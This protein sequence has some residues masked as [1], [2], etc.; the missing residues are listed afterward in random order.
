VEQ[1]PLEGASFV[2]VLRDGDAAPTRTTQHFEMLGSRAIYHDGWKA[3]TFKPLGPMYDDGLD[4]DAPFDEDRWELYHVAEDH[5]E[6]HDLAD[7][8]PDRLAAM[9]ERWWAEARAHQVLPLDNRPLAALLAPRPSSASRDRDRYS[10]FAGAAPVPETVAVNVRNRSHAMS[11][12]VHVPPGVVAYGVLL[13][14]GSTLGGWSLYLVDGVLHYVH[15]LTGSQLSRVVADRPVPGGGH[16]RLGFG[17]T[18]TADFAGTGRLFLDEEPVGELEIPLFTPARFSITGS[19]LTCGYEV[20]PAI[21]PDYTAPHRF[22]GTILRAVVDV[23][24]APYR[25][26]AAELAAIMAEQ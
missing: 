7:A 3:V 26:V 21:A 11:V 6:C 13:A 14:Q 16:H 23:T 2:S 19:G 8:E 17:F 18:R 20:G 4:P 1:T 9:I 15:N 25:D 24:G 5:S 10:Y 12:D 22:T